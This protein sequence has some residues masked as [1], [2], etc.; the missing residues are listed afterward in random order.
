[1]TGDRPGGPIRWR[2]HLGVS[3]QRVYEAL[4]SDDDRG[5]FWAEEAI[6]RDGAIHFVFINGYRCRSPV[7]D[8]RPGEFLVID[9]IGGP[10][11]FELAPDGQG[12]TDLFLVHEGVGDEE[13]NDVHAGW[14]N[15]LLPLKAWVEHGIDLHARDPRRTWDQG[16]ADH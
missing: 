12:G 8:R 4:T 9:Y 10:V 14:L 11:R 6:E 2:L 16:Y 1:M 5:A 7:L 13:W 3:P 15:V